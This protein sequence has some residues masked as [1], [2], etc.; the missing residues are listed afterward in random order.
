MESPP[1]LCTILGRKY[2]FIYN[3]F[4]I[5]LTKVI[6]FINVYQIKNCWSSYININDNILENTTNN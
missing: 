6:N 4:T 2:V 5:F 3:D 1:L